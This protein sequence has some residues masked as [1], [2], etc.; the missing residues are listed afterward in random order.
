MDIKL[1][2]SRNTNEPITFD[3]IDELLVKFE[4]ICNKEGFRISNCNRSIG[5]KFKS[6]ELLSKDEMNL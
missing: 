1:E 2:I 3:D 4:K 5:N 6:D